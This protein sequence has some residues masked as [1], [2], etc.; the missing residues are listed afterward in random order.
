MGRWHLAQCRSPIVTLQSGKLHCLTCHGSPPE[1]SLTPERNTNTFLPTP[2]DEPLGHLNLRWPSTVNYVNGAPQDIDQR[3]RISAGRDRPNQTHSYVY[4]RRLQHNEIRLAHLSPSPFHNAPLHIS[5]ATY[6]DDDYPDYEAVSYTWGDDTGDSNPS[7]PA[8]IGPFFDILLLTRNCAAM[9]L[10]ARRPDV[11]RPLWVDAICINQTDILEKEVQIPKM[12][13]IYKQCLRVL[14][15]LGESATLAPQHRNG[16]MFP[17]RRPLSDLSRDMQS[18]GHM[19]GLPYFSRLWVI[20][21]LILAR[22]A[23]FI[24]L[25][26]EYHTEAMSASKITF[27]M[28]LAPWLSHLGQQFLSSENS[29]IGALNLTGRA[30]CADIRDR[31]FGILGLVH[32]GQAE[33]LRPDYTISALHVFVGLFSHLVVVSGYARRVLRNAIGVRGWDKQP[34]WVPDWRS[35][36]GIFLADFSIANSCREDLETLFRQRWRATFSVDQ[37]IWLDEPGFDFSFDPKIIFPLPQ[38]CSVDANSGALTTRLVH[39]CA[40][41]RKLHYLGTH[42]ETGAQHSIHLYE[43][44]GEQ[45]KTISIIVL[46]HGRNLHRLVHPATDHIFFAGP[47]VPLLVRKL[48]D[49]DYRIVASLDSVYL[50]YPWASMQEGFVHEPDINALLDF[51]ATTSLGVSVPFFTDDRQLVD[52]YLESIDPISKQRR[53]TRTAKT[54]WRQLF[55]GADTLEAALPALQGVLQQQHDG[56]NAQSGW[57]YSRFD[58][59]NRRFK[60]SELRNPRT[61]AIGRYI[62]FIFPASHFDYVMEHYCS[63]LFYAGEDP[64]GSCRM[65]EARLYDQEQLQWE[66]LRQGHW[67]ALHDGDGPGGKSELTRH[68]AALR[69]PGLE[70]ASVKLRTSTAKAIYILTHYTWEMDV[71]KRL[72]RFDGRTELERLYKLSKELSWMGKTK[73]KM[74]S[75]F[76]ARRMAPLG[77]S[78]NVVDELGIDG[79]VTT[80]R[81]F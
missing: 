44:P 40:V 51:Q 62:E 17:K 8:Y 21:E 38:R 6:L 7:V 30:T 54:I 49:T 36:E 29:F 16:R 27:D 64:D 79:F 78:R 42:L 75:I 76:P 41:R 43:L 74:G 65:E 70:H 57:F 35:E 50:A 60:A 69:I 48:N 71:L 46:S 39:F 53:E 52:A 1:R 9:L 13:S 33:L 59:I 23:V 31:I 32:G 5:L 45:S 72:G 80:V 28:T 58:A 15:Y 22:H 73:Q 55:P 34:S 26:S 4:P 20:Q 12:A 24:Y 61:N 81:I 2:P 37:V 10:Y 67:V 3:A 68:I 11:Q 25:G 66:W 14:V 19:L 18:F 63:P 77:W 56:V 47:D